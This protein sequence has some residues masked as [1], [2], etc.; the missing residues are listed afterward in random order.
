MLIFQQGEG[1]GVKLAEHNSA[2]AH[3]S[4]SMYF[5]ANTLITQLAFVVNQMPRRW[6]TFIRKRSFKKS[7]VCTKYS[8][9]LHSCKMNFDSSAT[10]CTVFT[11]TERR[12]EVI[13][14]LQH[15]WCVDVQLQIVEHTLVYHSQVF[16]KLIRYPVAADPV[17]NMRCHCLCVQG[18]EWKRNKTQFLAVAVQTS[19]SDTVLN[20]NV[21]AYS[22]LCL[23]QFW[24]VRK[25][26]SYKCFMF[27]ICVKNPSLCFY[28]DTYKK[29]I[30][31]VFKTTLWKD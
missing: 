16:W 9:S 8:W 1:L 10:I 21:L 13:L 31:E 24:P 20:V 18:A 30:L 27:C 23:T 22:N 29:T 12:G 4:Y 14:Y 11:V 6:K 7:S 28:F 3:D 15:I 2:K 26:L 19:V 5:M 17:L 25:Y